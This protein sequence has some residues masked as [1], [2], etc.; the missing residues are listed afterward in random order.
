[1]DGTTLEM[2]AQL[3]NWHRRITRLAG[4]VHGIGAPRDFEALV[5]ID[6][7]K[8]LHATARLKLEEFKAAG[9]VER[10]SLASGLR[11]AWGDMEAAVANLG[12]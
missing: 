11:N 9:D 5:Y 10:R 3:R 7:L 2:E 1:M 6:E 8:V 4:T 12:P